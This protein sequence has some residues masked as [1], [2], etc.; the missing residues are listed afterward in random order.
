M[1]PVAHNDD[2]SHP[3]PHISLLVP[4]QVA[5]QVVVSG[6]PSLMI[7]EAANYDSSQYKIEATGLDAAR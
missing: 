3:L 4:H 7:D 1:L 5:Q 2:A 6:H